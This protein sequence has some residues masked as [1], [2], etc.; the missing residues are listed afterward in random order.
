MCSYSTATAAAD[1]G[2]YDLGNLDGMGG[3]GGLGGFVDN[4]YGDGGYGGGDYDQ[5]NGGECARSL[6][7]LLSVI[8][9]A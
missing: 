9:C 1:L 4:D 7:Q 8:A 2:G 5:A 3:E 6:L